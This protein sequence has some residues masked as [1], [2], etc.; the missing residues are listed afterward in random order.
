MIEKIPDFLYEKLLNEYG[1]DLTKSIIKG[2]KEN[3]PTTFR[4]N[5][6]K[7]NVN[8]IKNILD[9]LNVKYSSADFLDTAF[10]LEED[11]KLQDLDIYKD[12]KIYIQSLSSMIP[13]L[14]LDPKEKEN[15]LDMCAAPGGK[16]TQI[17]CISENKAM[18]TACEK[19]RI[20]GERLKYNIEKQGATRTSVMFKDARY[21]DS[22]FSFDKILLDAPCSG[23]GTLNLSDNNSYKNFTLELVNRS[24]KT[25]IELL[26]KAIKMLK[27]GGELVYSTCSIL[28]EENEEII[29]KVLEQDDLV[30]IP[31]E[32]D[33][34]NKIETLPSN[35]NGAVTIMP[36]KSYEGFFV[37]KLKKV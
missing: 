18:V 20:R 27:K 22:Y 15:I 21:L 23:S 25:Q 3:R 14:I 2:Y 35:I 36:N 13:A 30:V 4:V 24:K 11:Y 6:L 8:E 12:G 37:V 9:D 26:K 31:I 28:K 5:T 17:A 33:S 10:I 32:K 34:L 19:N 16:T 7:S 29:N 1:E